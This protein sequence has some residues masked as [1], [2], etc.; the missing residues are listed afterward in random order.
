M[1]KGQR[2]G[3]STVPI[4]KFDNEA[5]QAG[6]G[7]V[8]KGQEGRC[9]YIQER[10]ARKVVILNPLHLYLCR[11]IYIDNTVTVLQYIIHL[12]V[13]AIMSI[14]HSMDQFHFHYYVNY[15]IGILHA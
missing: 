12:C 14:L 2:F 5:E 4:C 13:C 8:W 9:L 1:T 11:L 7:Y 6:C 10:L 15:R 3:Y